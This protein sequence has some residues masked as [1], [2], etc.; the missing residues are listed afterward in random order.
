MGSDV[1]TITQKMMERA[2]LVKIRAYSDYFQANS[3]LR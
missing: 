2:G 3:T 1:S